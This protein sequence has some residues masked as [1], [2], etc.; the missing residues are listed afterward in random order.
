[1]RSRTP[2]SGPPI[3]S[4]ILSGFADSW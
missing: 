4:H 1:L 2:P 3:R